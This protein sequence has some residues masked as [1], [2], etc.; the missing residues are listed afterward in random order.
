MAVPAAF[1]II[2]TTFTMT[3]KAPPTPPSAGA[4]EK[5]G[6]FGSGLKVS[7]II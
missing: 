7:V 2:L 1:T 5:G 4:L 3:T 6:Y